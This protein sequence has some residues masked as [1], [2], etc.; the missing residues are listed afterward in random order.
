MD[1]RIDEIADGVFRISTFLP[2]PPGSAG[3][4]T[5]P[6]M[7]VNQFLV[8]ADEPLLFHTGMRATFPGT[9]EAIERALPL[10]ALRWVSFGHVEADECGALAPLLAAAPHARVAYGEAGW[11]GTIDDMA[12]DV[13]IDTV[14]RPVRRLAAG[15]R[16]DIGGRRLLH[17]A[18]PHAP[19]NVEAQVLFEET[20]GTLLAGDLFA[21]AGAGPAVTVRDLVEDAIATEEAFPMASPGPAVPHALRGLATLR[22]QTIATMHGSSYEG[23]G[24]SALSRLAD[25]WD[26]R[27]GATAQVAAVGQLRSSHG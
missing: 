18:T 10:A 27:F 14:E 17:L 19:H 23:D 6:G 13:G 2:G 4:A 20:T 22:P 16:L 25:A 24:A 12:I 21:Q 15:D 1:T 7:S 11:P 8:L 9:A 5:P 3:V 26:E